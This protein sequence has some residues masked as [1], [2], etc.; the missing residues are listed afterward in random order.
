MQMFLIIRRKIDSFCAAI[1]VCCIHLLP[2]G[3]FPRALRRRF[4]FPSF[5]SFLLDEYFREMYFAAT[6]KWFNQMFSE[7]MAKRFHLWMVFEGCSCSLN[8]SFSLTFFARAFCVTMTIKVNLWFPCVDR[9]QWCLLVLLGRKLETQQVG[10]ST[11]FPDRQIC[12]KL[13]I[14]TKR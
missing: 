7:W 12:S 8:V 3:V 1:P 2:D 14:M 13:L 10:Q 4:V 5:G 11:E 6:A 9:V